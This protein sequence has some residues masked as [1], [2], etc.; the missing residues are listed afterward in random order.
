MANGID[1]IT[2]TTIRSQEPTRHIAIYSN[3]LLDSVEQDTFLQSIKKETGDIRAVYPYISA[4]VTI[5]SYYSLLDAQR[6]LDIIETRY[7]PHQKYNAYY[8]KPCSINKNLNERVFVVL[9]TTGSDSTEKTTPSLQHFD[10]M[11][12]E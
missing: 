5:I 1:N 6:C 11:A 7:Y 9:T 2:V 12:R 4:S 10:Y 3:Y 8:A